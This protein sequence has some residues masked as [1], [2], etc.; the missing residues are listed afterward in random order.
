M[1]SDARKAYEK[2]KKGKKGTI[3]EIKFEL[4]IDKDKNKVKITKVDE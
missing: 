1:T 4:E 2:W 3:T